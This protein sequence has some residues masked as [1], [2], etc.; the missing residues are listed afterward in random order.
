MEEGRRHTH[1][2]VGWAWMNVDGR[3]HNVKKKEI[4]LSV[5]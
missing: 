3:K 5:V 4:L 2:Q 1:S